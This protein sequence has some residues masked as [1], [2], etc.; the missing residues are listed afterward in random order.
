MPPIPREN[1]SSTLLMRGLEELV[2]LVE[3]SRFV[4]PCAP[5][6]GWLHSGYKLLCYAFGHQHS[7]PDPSGEDSVPR[8]WTENGNDKSS[9]SSLRQKEFS[10]T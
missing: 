5:G 7:P 10:D 8:K 3:T 9:A 6:F 1:G 4:Y 2:P